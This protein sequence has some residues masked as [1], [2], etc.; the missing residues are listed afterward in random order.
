MPQLIFPL[1][2][3]SDSICSYG[4]LDYNRAFVDRLLVTA[5]GIE[6]AALDFG[7]FHLIDTSASLYLCCFNT[8]PAETRDLI[9]T[10]SDYVRY[11]IPPLDSAALL[12]DPETEDN[13]RVPDFTEVRVENYALVKEQSDWQFTLRALINYETLLSPSVRF[14]A[15][16][17]SDS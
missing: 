2:H 15:V 14:D 12:D 3:D 8:V 6:K 4:V 11:L 17:F 16:E 7:G 1:P 9:Y 13:I 10:G 5:K